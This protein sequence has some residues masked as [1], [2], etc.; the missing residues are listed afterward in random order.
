MK[1]TD[2][3]ISVDVQ[4]FLLQKQTSLRTPNLKNLKSPGETATFTL[5]Y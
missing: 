3:T 5:Q 1:S 2:N 4:Y